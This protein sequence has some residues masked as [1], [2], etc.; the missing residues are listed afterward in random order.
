MHVEDRSVHVRCRL[1]RQEHHRRRH[2]VGTTDPP[3]RDLAGEGAESVRSEG[4][5]ELVRA[6]VP[7]DPDTLVQ[8]VLE[9]LEMQRNAM[10]MYTSCGWFFNDVSGIETVQVLHYAARVI[11]LA[12]RYTNQPLEHDLLIRLAVSFPSEMTS[13]AFFRLT[14]R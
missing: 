13:S 14:P 4:P 6:H 9:L 11:Q 5:L 3:E 2:L 12:E 7:V 1:G 8:T 10:L